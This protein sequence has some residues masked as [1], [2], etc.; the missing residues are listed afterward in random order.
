[1][2]AEHR[3]ELE[4]NALAERMGQMA[5]AVKGGT[6]RNALIGWGIFLLLVAG[7]F[8][9]SYHAKNALAKRSAMWT[10][11]DMA[12]TITNVEKLVGESA[13][14]IAGR[15]ARF[16]E[17]RYRLQFGV[18]NLGNAD[19]VAAAVEGL[20][21]A[22]EL[23]ETLTPESKDTPLLAQEALMGA[24]KAEESLS[25]SPREPGS[26]E[27]WGSLDRALEMYD[28]LAADYADSFQGK[29]AADRAKQIRDNRAAIES[30]YLDLSQRVAKK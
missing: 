10:S 6:S 20:K 11:L 19:Q 21:R 3:K 7:L 13:G 25:G 22:R 30:F 2:K 4:R 9:Y 1:M 28:K 29:T 24:A 23:Y 5:G 12:G 27:K 8:F 15:T 16:E 14:T 18:G 26:P 17:A